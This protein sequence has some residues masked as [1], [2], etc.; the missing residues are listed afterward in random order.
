MTARSAPYTPVYCILVKLLYI[1]SFKWHGN[2][3]DNPNVNLTPT[4]ITHSAL[5][6]T[7]PLVLFKDTTRP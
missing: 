7:P 5:P 4:N 2:K 3:A 6:Q 1:C